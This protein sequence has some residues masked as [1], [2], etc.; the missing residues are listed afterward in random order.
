MMSPDT[1]NWQAKAVNPWTTLVASA[2]GADDWGGFLIT[3]AEGKG[4]KKEIIKKVP[5]KVPHVAFG[6]AEVAIDQI[7]LSWAY[8]DFTSQE[9]QKMSRD[10]E[11]S[12]AAKATYFVLERETNGSGKWEV[13]AEKLETKVDL[14]RLE[15]RPGEVRV[16]RPAYSTDKLLKRGGPI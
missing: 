11:K 8:K 15:D 9:I 14:H 7:S 16:P 12:D 5:V 13:L 1:E 2:R 3:K 4:L 10:K 6:N